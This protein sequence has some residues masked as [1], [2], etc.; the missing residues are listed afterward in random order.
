MKDLHIISDQTVALPDTAYQA[1][2]FIN[3][4]MQDSADGRK[5]DRVSPS[6]GVVVSHDLNYRASLWSSH[7]DPDAARIINREIAGLVDVLVGDEYAYAACLGIE[8][9][10]RR[11][12][13]AAAAASRSAIRLRPNMMA[14]T[15]SADTPK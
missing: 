11:S 13:A 6:H 1:R 4:V 2:H 9:G 5:S 10:D 7:P 3:G 8:T 15:M 14:A 12:D